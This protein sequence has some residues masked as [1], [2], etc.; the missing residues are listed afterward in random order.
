M[1][2]ILFFLTAL[3]WTVF[4]WF[5]YFEY[6]YRCYIDQ[7]K[8]VISLNKEDENFKKC[9][10]IL[11]NIYKQLQYV[12][13]NI[14]TAQRYIEKDP[15]WQKV[16]EENLQKKQI[17]EKLQ[18]TL[19]EKIKIFEQEFF[20]R[21]KKYLQK[22]ISYWLLQYQAYKYNLEKQYEQN[23]I[24]GDELS[25]KEI[26]EKLDKVVLAIDL[27]QNIQNSENFETLIPFLRAFVMLH[28]EF[29]QVFGQ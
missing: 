2:K 18:Q 19:L 5:S 11:S 23:L 17:L 21:I 13:K 26:I 28:N 14:Q 22:Y 8:I 3:F 20:N 1:K 15:F 4:F 6:K 12:E 25:L 24:K 7:D 16:L 10:E 29:R 9:L 27:L